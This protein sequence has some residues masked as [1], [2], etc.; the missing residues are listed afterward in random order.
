[1]LKIPG[2]VS[3]SDP[4]IKHNTTL[5]TAVNKK[6]GISAET[7]TLTTHHTTDA[8]CFNLVKIIRLANTLIIANIIANV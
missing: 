8:G 5:P 4:V 6:K 1:V 2:N 7:N 3:R